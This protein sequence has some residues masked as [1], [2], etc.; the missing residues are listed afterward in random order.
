MNLS[1]Y[2]KLTLEFCKST[3]LNLN[4]QYLCLG[5][6]EESGEVA[7]KVKKMRRDGAVNPRDIA[8]EMGDVLWYTARFADNIGLDIGEYVPL[9]AEVPTENPETKMVLRLNIETARIATGELD[10]D[11]GLIDDGIT[12]VMWCLASLG[13]IIGYDIEQVAEMNIEKL[14]SRKE[15][16]VL[17]GNGDNR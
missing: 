1:E 10:D 12:N 13:E 15:R 6:V 4:N 16:G 5:L 8:L 14:R 2:Q 17:G 11:Q 3:E 7:G 9:I